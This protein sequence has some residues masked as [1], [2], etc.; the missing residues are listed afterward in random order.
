MIEPGREASIRRRA[1][2]C[3]TKKAARRLRE[4]MASKSA[5]VTS[6]KGAGRF[7]PALLT[8]MSKGAAS[9]MAARTAAIS[10]T[11]SGMAAAASPRARIAAA[12][13]SISVCV[14]AAS[15]TWAPACASADAAASPMPRPPPVTSARLPSRRNDGAPVSS[16]GAAA[17]MLPLPRSLRRLGI[18]DVAAAVAAHAHIGLL[19]MGE[20]ALENAQPRAIF[21]DQGGGFVG[22]HLLIGAGLE[23]LADP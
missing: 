9:A 21:P 7:I 12:A 4:T 18:G 17:L 15:V 20:E 13:A 8:R 22:E 1:T 11:S 14:R 19:G 6:T 2:A 3:A 10:V 5:T 16:I 23:E